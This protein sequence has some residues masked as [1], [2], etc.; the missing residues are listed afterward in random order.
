VSV[1][2]RGALTL[3]ALRRE[4]VTE[5]FYRIVRAYTSGFGEVSKSVS[6]RDLDPLFDRSLSLPCR[7]Q[8]LPTAP[9][10]RATGKTDDERRQCQAA[11]QRPAYVEAAPRRFCR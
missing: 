4:V 7:S 2:N 8:R 3:E 9:R 10:S 11:S 1:Y 6:G 5:N